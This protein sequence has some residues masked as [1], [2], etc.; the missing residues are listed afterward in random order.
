MKN[1]LNYYQPVLDYT[2]P[3]LNY[4]TI[5]ILKQVVELE[6]IYYKN[7]IENIYNSEFYLFKSISLVVDE[8]NCGTFKNCDGKILTF[9]IPHTHHIKKLR[10][11]IE[12][13]PLN[14]N[15][16]LT[17]EFLLY[18]FDNFEYYVN[19]SLLYRLHPEIFAISKIVNPVYNYT[20]DLKGITFE[21]QG[22]FC[23]LSTDD[24]IIEELNQEKF[25]IKTDVRKRD[26]LIINKSYLN[27]ILCITIV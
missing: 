16:Q 7:I 21:R 17:N 11:N 6:G 18:T 5:L 27:P 10:F 19:D 22:C 20:I 23:C 25:Y 1:I 9:K 14:S 15:F 3:N 24:D 13:Y 26:E 4:S 8:I 2:L 12:T